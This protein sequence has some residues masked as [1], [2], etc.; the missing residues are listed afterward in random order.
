MRRRTFLTLSVPGACA[1]MNLL[2]YLAREEREARADDVGDALADIAKA[3]TGLQTLTGTFTQERTIGLLATAVKSEGELTIVRPD[4][5][6][7]ELRPPDAITYWIGPE[8]LAYETPSGGAS[9]GKSAAGRFAAVLGDLMTLM[10]GD[11]AK[12]RARYD[13][14]V[15]RG[16]AGLVLGARP[17][18]DDVK[19][20]VR[21]LTLRLRPNLWSVD[22]VEI[23][24]VSGDRSVIS[25]AAMT[26]DAKVDP[27][28]M[29]P[30]KGR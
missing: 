20:H 7:W 21:S 26:R 10:G 14:A 29:L 18:A 13:L 9:V 15:E 4:R 3:R 23:E 8:G 12:L 5:L 27:A 1:A 19:K 6:R 22:R 30:P 16:E 11:L 28:R 25:F 17:T 24:E 2:P